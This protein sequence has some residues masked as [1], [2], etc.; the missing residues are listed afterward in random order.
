MVCPESRG[1]EESPTLQPA[2][3][4]GGGGEKRG[5][6]GRAQSCSSKHKPMQHPHDLSPTECLVL[7]TYDQTQFPSSPRHRRVSQGMVQSCHLAQG[8]TE[9]VQSLPPYKDP[10]EKPQQAPDGTKGRKPN[11][12]PSRT[13]PWVPGQEYKAEQSRR[14]QGL[15]SKQTWELDGLLEIHK[16]NVPYCFREMFPGCSTV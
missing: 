7:C 14:Q 8:H 2:G 1:R 11:D 3:G 6:A 16:R 15:E 5:A 13:G 12:L 10:W 4:R 9:P